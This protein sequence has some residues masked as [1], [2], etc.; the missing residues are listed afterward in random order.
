[1]E[2]KILFLSIA[3]IVILLI[4]F[5]LF[6]NK[7]NSQNRVEIISYE[8]GIQKE[9]PSNLR[10]FDVIQSSGENVFT[11]SNG[12]LD[13]L[14]TKET[15]DKYKENFAIEI[16]YPQKKDFIINSTKPHEITVKALLIAFT[17]SNAIIFYKV[18]DSYSSG[19]YINTNENIS[20]IKETI[21][22]ITRG[23]K[24]ER[25]TSD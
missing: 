4:L 12:V 25:L 10:E 1:M 13:L 22:N 20:S 11:N 3:A 19:P 16:I 2:R 24:T 6:F 17:D 21:Q 9:I 8:K 7:T 15:I 5:N 14:V 18:N 23:I